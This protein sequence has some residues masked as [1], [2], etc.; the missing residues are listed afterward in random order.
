MSED[1]PVPQQWLEI[2]ATRSGYW[3][4]VSHKEAG[5]RPNWFRRFWMWALFEMEWKQ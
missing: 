2:R 5:W 4:S 3:C 1:K